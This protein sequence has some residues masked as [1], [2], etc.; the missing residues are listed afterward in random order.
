MEDSSW[1]SG[2]TAGRKLKT[3]QKFAVRIRKNK[4]AKGF[5]LL[6][7]L[8]RTIIQRRLIIPVARRGVAIRRAIRVVRVNGTDPG[9]VLISVVVLH[10]ADIRRSIAGIQVRGVAIGAA[11]AS[12]ANHC[13]QTHND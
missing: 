1:F 2:L 4:R 7:C 6:P 8:L 12:K 10:Y 9:G 11:A 3:D 5:R 13:Q